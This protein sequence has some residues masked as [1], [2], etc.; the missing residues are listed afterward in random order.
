MGGA[1][2]KDKLFY[3]FTY[4]GSRKV[5]PISYTSTAFPTAGSPNET[6]PAVITVAQCAAANAFLRG[7][8]GSFARVGV[9]DVAFGKLD[10]QLN[11]S[12]HLSADIR[13]E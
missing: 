8:L 4:D 11:S 9:N 13:L 5:F 6:C 10:Y 7:N 1:A 12:N 3:F 2:I